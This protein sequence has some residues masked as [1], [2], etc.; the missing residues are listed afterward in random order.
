MPGADV[1]WHVKGYGVRNPTVGQP[2]HSDR[3]RIYVPSK[4]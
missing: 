1:V 2:F 4:I 3:L